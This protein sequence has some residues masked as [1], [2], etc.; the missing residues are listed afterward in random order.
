MGIPYLFTFFVDLLL[1]FVLKYA[2]ISVI[3]KRHYILV[4]REGLALNQKIPDSYV[5]L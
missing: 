4:E 1:T 3:R 2:I 5:F